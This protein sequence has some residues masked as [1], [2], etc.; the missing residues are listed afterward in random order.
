[1]R[2][3]A[4]SSRRISTRRRP[5]RGRIWRN[6]DAPEGNTEPHS[7]VVRSA[8]PGAAVLGC[9]LARTHPIITDDAGDAQAIVAEHAGT[10]ACLR[11]AVLLRGAPGLHRG[12]V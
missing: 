11:G 9:L 8:V 7:P 5:R 3:D 6:S 12:L 2:W 1:M 4:G 10:A